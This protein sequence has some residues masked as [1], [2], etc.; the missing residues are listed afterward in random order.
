MHGPIVY[1]AANAREN[2][3]A[4]HAG[5]RAGE[6]V[7][8]RDRCLEGPSSC[9]SRV[10]ARVPVRRSGRGADSAAAFHRLP[11]RVRSRV[12]RDLATRRRSGSCRWPSASASA[13]PWHG[14]SPPTAGLGPG[15]VTLT[16]FTADVDR[17]RHAQ[18]GGDGGTPRAARNEETACGDGPLRRHETKTAVTGR[19][20]RAPEHAR[21]AER[22]RHAASLA[23]KRRSASSPRSHPPR[24]SSLRRCARTGAARALRT[25]AGDTNSIGAPASRFSVMRSRAA[26][27]QAGVKARK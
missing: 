17:Q 26:H 20:S 11:R 3:C 18:H 10:C 4:R 21:A 8:V 22:P 25:S 14:R 9:G 27:A 12:S 23:G 13:V 7:E 19:R 15:S 6:R 1:P 5:Q 24:S 16:V 2:E